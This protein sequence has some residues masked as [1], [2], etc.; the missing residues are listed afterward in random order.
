MAAE[1]ASTKRCTR[2]SET[3]AVEDFGINRA[4]A[5][6][7]HIYCRPCARA[8]SA[9]D[10]ARHPGRGAAWV[11]AYR[12][13]NPTEVRERENA[14]RRAKTAE[15]LAANAPPA[16]MKRCGCCKAVKPQSDFGKR[17]RA[18]DGLHPQ[19]KACR[20]DEGRRTYAASREKIKARHDLWKAENPERYRALVRR[21]QKANPDKMRPLHHAARARRRGAEGRYTA[22]DLQEI[23]AA[24]RDKCAYCRIRLN[25]KGSVDHIAPLSKGGTNDRRNLQLVCQPCN[26]RKSAKDPLAFAQSRGLLL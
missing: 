1:Q 13:K 26:S 15:R 3:K 21:W 11:A 2:C 19:C 6:G 25:G 16:G 24:Q 8:I 10:R 23:R 4:I 20:A 7:R 9:E 18:K 22:K 17:P 14:Q 5:D 12:A